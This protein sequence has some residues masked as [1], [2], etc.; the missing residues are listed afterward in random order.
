MQSGCCRGPDPAPYEAQ[1]AGQ[2]KKREFSST[3]ASISSNPSGKFTRPRRIARTGTRLCPPVRTLPL[4]ARGLQNFDG[5]G[6]AGG[7][8]L[9][10][11][12]PS[13]VHPHFPRISAHGSRL[14]QAASQRSPRWSSTDRTR[15]RAGRPSC[16]VRSAPAPHAWN[17]S[18]RAVQ[19]RRSPPHHRG[20]ERPLA[21]PIP[22]P[23][24]L[25]GTGIPTRPD[26][27]AAHTPPPVCSGAGPV[28]AV[29]TPLLRRSR[30]PEACGW[31]TYR[32][33]AIMCSR[34]G[35]LS[36]LTRMA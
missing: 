10:M 30:S 26:E 7:T 24:R 2:G 32:S 12:Q 15:H 6:D 20:A 16:R 33:A 22:V 27:T 34:S 9:R 14:G 3:S 17:T 19:S 28:T 18:A 4:A 25:P 23:G 11:V 31:R 21:G 35:A 5:L 29:L 36:G 1:S 13:W 8:A